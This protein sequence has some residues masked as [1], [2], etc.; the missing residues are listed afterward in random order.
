MLDPWGKLKI[1]EMV[2]GPPLTELPTELQLIAG[3]MD[4][5]GGAVS[6]RIVAIPRLTDDELR[7]LA[8]PIL[9]VVGGRD[10]LIDSAE[11]RAARALR[12]AC[13]DMLHR[14]RLSFSARP[15]RTDLPFLEENAPA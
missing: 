6:T 2:Y 13:R 8:M 11:T 15:V 10:V 9:A 5:I 4:S 14:E 7:M 12:A 1:R 3:L